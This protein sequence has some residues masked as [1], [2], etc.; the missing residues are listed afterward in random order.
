MAEERLAWMPEHDTGI[1]GRRER[2]E[3]EGKEDGEMIV[4]VKSWSEGQREREAI[5]TGHEN[6]I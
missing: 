3:E 6:T 1:L 5:E 4:C 2:R